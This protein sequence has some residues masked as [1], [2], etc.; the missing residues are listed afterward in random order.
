MLAVKEK[1]R[2]NMKIV[3]P[4]ESGNFTQV[5][6]IIVNDTRLDLKEKGL[7]L[8]ILSKSDGW[9]LNVDEIAK[10][11][12][13]GKRAIYSG[14]KK[15][16]EFGY[17][18]LKADHD[19]MGKFKRWEYIIKPIPSIQIVNNE[20][21][22]LIHNAQMRNAHVQ[23]RHYNNTN[24]NNTNINNNDDNNTKKNHEQKDLSFEGNNVETSLISF[25]NEVDKKEISLKIEN[26]ANQNLDIKL[27]SIENLQRKSEMIRKRNPKNIIL[28]TID[29]FPEF[30][31][32]NKAH[33]DKTVYTDNQSFNYLSKILESDCQYPKWFNDS[34]K[35][36]EV[37]KQVNNLEDSWKSITN[38]WKA[39]GSRI[40]D[41]IKLM[42]RNILCFIQD[43]EYH[44]K[45]NLE[46]TNLRQLE[47]FNDSVQKT[48]K[49][50][51]IDE[52]VNLI[53]E[54]HSK[55]WNSLDPFRKELNNFFESGLNL[56][57]IHSYFE[58]FRCAN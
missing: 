25:A 7:M 19:E 30:V 46:Y 34:Y 42:I 44:Q 57:T 15:L 8:H 50:K 22:P 23:S 55:N 56:E 58:T 54:Y 13:D 32:M 43:K 17:I 26:L 27:S 51:S 11:N 40:D 21:Y 41:S 33:G 3:K 18:E 38:I 48:L 6:N 37:K 14:I 49:L 5:S 28:E 4:F 35:Q 52:I 2:S 20:P 45:N 36:E 1:F 9:F 31:R 47:F 29:K 24:S 39:Q 12:R 53:K 10:N 16:K